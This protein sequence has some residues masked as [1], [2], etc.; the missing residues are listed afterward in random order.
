M[1]CGFDARG[2]VADRA[3]DRSRS[4]PSAATIGCLA[5]A[6][7]TLVWRTPSRGDVDD[8]RDAARGDAR[9]ARA[10]HVDAQRATRRDANDATPATTR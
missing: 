8:A 2:A 5:N 9:D 1:S 4:S 7:A 10:R 6:V 3:R